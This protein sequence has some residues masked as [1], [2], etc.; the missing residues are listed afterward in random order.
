MTD[1]D[2]RS[3]RVTRP[4]A[5]GR[6][7]VVAVVGAYL[8][9]IALLRKAFDVDL[10]PYLGVN[11]ETTVFYDARNVLAALECRRLGLDPLVDNPCDPGDRVL[12]YPRVWLL[13]RHL[14]LDQSHTVL[15]GS[16]FV[17]VLLAA[18]LLLVG[19]LTTR[20]GVV[21]AAAVCSPA[22]MLSVERGNVD[23][24]LFA[25]FVAAAFAWHRGRAWPL[26]PLLVALAAVA[27]LYGA[28]A[29]PALLLDARTGRRRAA[30]LAT[31]AAFA[32]SLAL[33]LDDLRT[34]AGA[35]EGGL[36]YSYGARILP[37]H[38]YHAVVPGEWERGTLVAQAIVAL[39]VLVLLV[40]L[41]RR[42][43]RTRESGS[44]P[45]PSPALLAFQ[46][47]TLVYLLTFLLRKNGDYRLVL[48]LLLLPQL[49][50]WTRTVER[51]RSGRLGVVA[52]LLALYAG[53]LSPWI[54]PWD[55]LASWAL[56]G[57]LVVLLAATLPRHVRAARAP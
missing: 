34:V 40:L 38:L 30:V 52:V 53:A 6:L 33:T 28:F 21:L 26:A 36:L 39:P 9:T 15:V 41:G 31:A 25:L 17:V 14:G 23:V 24:L 43:W 42:A 49:L 20:E 55:E 8:G 45:A 47:G 19:R 56:A 13:L 44:A 5:D 37:G 32:A 12:V 35:A 22:V 46:M 2:V 10:W 3:R 11:A 16:A 54:G 29:L 18:L 7:L 50:D 57:V 1:V 51:R 48:L 4:Q 27:K